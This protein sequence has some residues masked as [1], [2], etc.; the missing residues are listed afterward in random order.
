MICTADGTVQLMHQ[1]AREFFLQITRHKPGSKFDLSSQKAHGVIATTSIQYLMLC[2]GNP[3]TSVEGTLS[4][5]KSWGSDS[6]RDYAT[7]LSLWPWINY[8]ISNLYNHQESCDRGEHVLHLVN[9]LVKQ[10]TRIPATASLGKWVTNH[11]RKGKSLHGLIR[12]VASS[13]PLRHILTDSTS[14]D[15]NYRVL[16]AAAALDLPRVFELVQR[17]TLW[18]PDE[19][20]LISSVRKGLAAA[21]RELI[22]QGYDINAVDKAG[23]SAL[24]HAAENGDVPMVR[25]LKEGGA[26][27]DIA[28]NHGIRPIDVA[29]KAW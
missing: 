26:A 8:A 28:D 27:W 16:D 6:F 7:Y 13:T 5:V 17:S 25:L 9:T 1:T 2:L 14:N 12:E 23:R 10:L 20:Q 15:F 3:D 22:K 21:S 19:V 24:Y 11:R 18:V 29:A 4:D